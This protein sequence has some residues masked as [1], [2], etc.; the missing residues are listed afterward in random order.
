MSI[1]GVSQQPV[2]WSTVTILGLLPLQFS[3]FP[4]KVVPFQV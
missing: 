2:D 4:F 1:Q 3:I